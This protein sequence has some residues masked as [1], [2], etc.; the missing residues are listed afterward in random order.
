MVEAEI[1]LGRRDLA[2]L[3]AGESAVGVAGA[4]LAGEVLVFLIAHGEGYRCVHNYAGGAGECEVARVGGPAEAGAGR[5]HNDAHLGGRHA[6]AL[7]D[8][9]DG[10][11]NALGFAL[12]RK[13]AVLVEVG[14]N[15]VAFDGKVRLARGV[16]AALDAVSGFI[17]DLRDLARLLET[18]ALKHGLQAVDVR[19]IFVD[20]LG[21]R[22]G[23]FEEVH[24]GRQLFDVHLYLGGSRAGMLLGV[25][26]REGDHV[27]V[28]V[29][30]VVC[31]NLAGR[32]S[33]GAAL[34]E[35]GFG[36]D[37]AAAGVE[38]VL[39]EDDLRHAGHLLGF[40]NVYLEDLGVMGELRLDH[41]DME[42]VGRHLE[43]LIVAVIGETADL[44]E[45]GGTHERLAVVLA[46]L[47]HLDLDV[48]YR[49]LAAHNSGS[50]HDGVDDLLVAGAAADVLVLSE[51][52]ADFLACGVVVLDQQSIGGDHEARRAETAL[53]G[54]VVH[55]GDL[56]RV[57]M[58]RGT[59]TLH[60]D[61]FAV[62]FDASDLSC[63]GA[64][65]LAVEQ[66][67]AGTADTDAA[68][69][70]N[71]GAA[72]SSEH[73]RQ[74]FGERIAHKHSVDAV[75]VQPHFPVRQFQIPFLL[76]NY[77]VLIFCGKFCFL[78]AYYYNL[79][80]SY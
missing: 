76:C 39:G 68:A 12:E 42:G 29:D 63:A 8:T 57:Q 64:D 19:G 58:V 21:I 31:Q 34:V 10:R 53:D 7:A 18:F 16:E 77:V 30:D 49:A 67:R 47:G 2:V 14:L 48:G 36:H 75:N 3:V 60:R 79:A 66:H 38:Q 20:A 51:P 78:R 27:A 5:V 13:E 41:G 70:L 6:E 61:N 52:V 26:D 24:V 50:V 74:R 62:L 28:A 37:V 11:I 56:D 69:N 32:H 80:V 44:G 43:L 45:R 22:H 1:E 35:V 72:E 33:D 40:G 46:V 23:G 71:A 15:C 9:G 54:A 17:D 55:K 65:Q 59:D 25:G 4:A 73:V